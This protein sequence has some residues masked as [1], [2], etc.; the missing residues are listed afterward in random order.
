[1]CIVNKVGFI[2]QSLDND[3]LFIQHLIGVVDS[4]DELSHL[5]ITKNHSNLSFRVAASLPIYNNLLIEEILKLHNMLNI[6]LDMSKSIKSSATLSF[7]IN[8]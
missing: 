8:M 7:R 5:Q 1:M 6:R 4:V 2:G 3:E